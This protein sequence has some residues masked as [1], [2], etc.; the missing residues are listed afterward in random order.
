MIGLGSDKNDKLNSLSSPL[1]A[2]AMSIQFFASGFYIFSFWRALSSQQ[3]PFQALNPTRKIT[4]EE[5]YK[6]H[7]KID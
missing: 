4:K 6:I 2:K 3:T 5:N 1:Q 7:N